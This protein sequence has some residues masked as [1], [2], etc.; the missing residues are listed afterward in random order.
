MA[1]DFPSN[2]VNGQVYTLDGIKYTYDE[3]KDYWRFGDISKVLI[4]I[5]YNDVINN[6]TL[7]KGLLDLDQTTTTHPF[8]LIGYN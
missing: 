6:S 5:P 8:L 1:I 2:P 3:S 4:D 7:F